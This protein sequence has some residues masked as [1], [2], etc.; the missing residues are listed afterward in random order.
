MNKYLKFFHYLLNLCCDIFNNQ[1]P[2]SYTVNH[3]TSRLTQQL[4]YLTI[5]DNQGIC[6]IKLYLGFPEA[7]L[8]H[9]DTSIKV[10]LEKSPFPIT[11]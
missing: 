6:D 2:V 3:K 4:H 10:E 11:E 7:Q 5:D 1:P 8:K 9:G